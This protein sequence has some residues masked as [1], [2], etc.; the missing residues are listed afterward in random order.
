MPIE[1]NLF[2]LFIVAGTTAAVLPG[3]SVLYVVSQSLY[4]GFKKT[5]PSIFGLITGTIFLG[6]LII[7]GHNL[8]VKSLVSEFAYFVK[9]VAC[10]GLVYMGLKRIFLKNKT[11]KINRD[12]KLMHTGKKDY[13]MGLMTTL[14]SPKVL[15][16]YLVF[17][18]QFVNPMHSVLKQL[19]VL[20]STQN[21]IKL[22]S[23]LGYSFLAKKISLFFQSEIRKELFNKISGSILIIAAIILFFIY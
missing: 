4:G 5:L 12:S 21:V 10:S 13:A 1:P 15:L 3:P 22:L 20:V 17:I 2:L 19:V 11:F 7:I 23:L 6:L 9:V 8:I 16:F 14:T 18:P